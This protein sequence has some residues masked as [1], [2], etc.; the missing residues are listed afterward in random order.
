MPPAIWASRHQRGGS[1][2]G[3]ALTRPAREE[4]DGDRR[5]EKAVRRCAVQVNVGD[6]VLVDGRRVGDP[7]RPGVVTAAR[8]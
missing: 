6:R 4:H 1:P 3:G 7:P 2:V 8:G 5:H